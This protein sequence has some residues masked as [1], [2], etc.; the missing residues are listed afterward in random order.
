MKFSS[1]P[2]LSRAQ[3]LLSILLFTPTTLSVDPYVE[4]P[5]EV[6]PDNADLRTLD[7]NVLSWS[8][9]NRDIAMYTV[10]PMLKHFFHDLSVNIGASISLRVG[11][12]ESDK[13]HYSPNNTISME[14]F[15]TGNYSRMNI[16]LGPNYFKAIDNYFEQEIRYIWCLNLRNR[17]NRYE[18][19]VTV[20]SG[21]LEHLGDQLDYF[22]IGNEADFLGSQ[23]F[24]PSDWNVQMM[25]PEWDIIV[26]RVQDLSPNKQIKFWAGGFAN[27]AYRLHQDFNVQGMLAAGYQG[28]HIPWYNLHLYPQSGCF[29]DPIMEALL[30]HDAT[31]KNISYYVDQVAAAES[32]G[33]QFLM[34]ESNTVS[35]SGIPGISDTFAAALWMVDWVL[36]SAS[37][38]IRRV[39]IQSG[40]QAP[41]SPIHPHDYQGI[42]DWA[43]NNYTAGILPLAYGAY[44]LSEVVSYDDSLIISAIE[45]GNDTDYSSYAFWDESNSLRKFVVLNLE[46]YKSNEGATNPST[47]DSQFEPTE[48]PRGRSTF[49]VSTPWP[50]GEELSIIKLQGPGSNAK[51][52]VNVS[53]FVWKE[54]SGEIDSNLV[55]EIL[56]VQEGGFVVFDLWASEAALVQ[57]YSIVTENEHPTKLNTT[58][59][60]TTVEGVV[61]RTRGAEDAEG[62]AGRVALS[63][64]MMWLTVMGAVFWTMT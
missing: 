60:S 53:H 57:P 38:G 61:L 33:A 5:I 34:G 31:V 18:G 40:T 7:R 43:D 3:L 15:Q 44:F 49:N 4:I 21:V 56:T 9:Q 13:A 59:A 11:G 54:D 25:K 6:P 52:G 30:H 32:V 23:G 14:R 41:Y 17:T 64:S 42:R 47:P 22:E 51:S 8:I 48:G 10:T 62:A 1:I 35:C 46:L 63:W 24:R 39:Y 16:T 36:Q 2:R 37:I 27:P 45:G 19:A 28:N 26:E 12:G 55:D 50:V 58:A 20:A 29:A